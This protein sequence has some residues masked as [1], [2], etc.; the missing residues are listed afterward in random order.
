V[1]ATGIPQWTQFYYPARNQFV[2]VWPLS[3]Y[4]AGAFRRSGAS[5]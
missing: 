1:T 4:A 2:T 3:F 5:H